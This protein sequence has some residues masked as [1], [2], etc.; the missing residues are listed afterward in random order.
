M[1]RSDHIDLPLVHK[2]F[3]TNLL[4]NTNNPA[5]YGYNNGR[6]YGADHAAVVS[7]GFVTTGDAV[8]P[9]M[10]VTRKTTLR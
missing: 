9:D 7:E 2:I 1:I 8:N 6:A 5:E 10:L 3:I 4:Q